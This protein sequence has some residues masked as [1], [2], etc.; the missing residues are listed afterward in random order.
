MIKLSRRCIY[1]MKTKNELRSAEILLRCSKMEHDN[2]SVVRDALMKNFKNVLEA[3]T[4]RTRIGKNDYC[5]AATALVKTG[6]IKKFKEEL[7]HL[8]AKAEQSI[9][10]KNLEVY[11]SQ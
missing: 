4:T 10:I 3:N 5:V 6:E 7:M 2:C 8:K 11:V 9:K 1:N